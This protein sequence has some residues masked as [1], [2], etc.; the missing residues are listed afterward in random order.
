LADSSVWLSDIP[1]H[2]FDWTDL[3]ITRPE[4][5]VFDLKPRDA[6]KAEKLKLMYE[7]AI[8]GDPSIEI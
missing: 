2:F 6:G 5:F 8:K 3:L 7:D 1:V 4:S